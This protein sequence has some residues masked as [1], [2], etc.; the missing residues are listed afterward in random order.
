[1]TFFCGQLQTETTAIEL[2]MIL[3]TGYKSA[4]YFFH[5]IL[6]NKKGTVKLCNTPNL[7]LSKRLTRIDATLI[8]KPKIPERHYRPQPPAVT[9]VLGIS[10]LYLQIV[11]FYPFQQFFDIFFTFPLFTN[12]QLS[13]C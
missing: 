12:A 9:L 4:E 13:G 6:I 7:H 2:K 11:V 1:M 8:G 10:S 3:A 5:T